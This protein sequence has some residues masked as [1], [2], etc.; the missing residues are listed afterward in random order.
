[1][2]LSRGALLSGAA[3]L[4]SVA[5]APLLADDKGAPR[6]AQE[7]SAKA[8]E[9][10]GQ[11]TPE[12]K[13]NLT[14]GYMAMPMLG[15]TPP[16]GARPGAGYVKGVP[17]LNVPPLWETDASLGVTWLDGARGTGG[18]QLPSGTAQGATWNPQL[19]EEGGR[20]IGSEAHAKGFNVLLAGGINL[21]R[22]ARN[23]RTFEYLGEDPLHSGIMGG[24]VVR[25]IQSNPVISTL[26]HFT[27]N[28]QE[29]G[30]QIMN[31]KISEAALRESDLLAFEIAIEQGDPGAIMCAYDAI[32]GPLSCG[33]EFLLTKVL[34]DDWGYKGFVMSDW[35][36]VD[37]LDFAM[38][39]LDQQSGSELDPEPYLGKPL[40][41]AAR[42]DPKWA[43]RLSEMA[44]HVLW[45]IYRFGLD[46]DPPTVSKVDTEADARVARK[47]AEEGIVL[48]TN[49]DGV[50]PFGSDVKSVA[51][52]GGHADA[53]TLVGGG[54]SR[55]MP[56]EG[57]SITVPHLR[58]DHAAFAAFIDAQYNRSSPLTA[59][60][61]GQPE[62]SFTFRDGRYTSEAAA[63]AARSDV[64]VVF[65]TQ[66]QT[67]GY[68][69]PDLS[70]PGNQDALIE[71]VA[72]A[73]PHTI[74]VLETGG[75]VLMP[76]KDKVAG[77]VEAWYPGARGGEAISDILFGKVNPSGRLPITFPQSVAQLPRPKLDGQGTIEPSFLGTGK[78]G[79]TF[80]VN[81]DI[82]GSDVGYRWFARKGEKPLFA[83][84]HGLTYTSFDYGPLRVQG[85]TDGIVKASFT[86]TNT[87]ERAGAEV[88][89]LYL[90]SVN[91]KP[92][93]RLAGFA[94]RDLEPGQKVK[95]NLTVDPRLLA[96]WEDGGW[97]L[98]GGEYGFALGKDAESLGQVVTIQ[99]GARRW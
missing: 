68:D 31:A 39:G 62:V 40:L 77:I 47:V 35:G 58:G 87:G 64:A 71:A 60:R 18:T 46:T 55:V 12:E 61:E 14:L 27:I 72:A 29:T 15:S 82:E 8:A 11:M 88:A 4:M 33:S 83:F 98:A 36:A 49:P 94:K 74:V 24:A 7:A 92:R 9:V 50:L 67:E 95:V 26:K 13:T 38:A 76:W 65:V 22:E 41:E 48:L 59:M 89:Q 51:V 56:D 3:I 53:G 21:M 73:N 99:L 43:A 44:R 96:N 90:T 78:P 23:G 79:E 97:S 6:T 66:F 32:N 85:G 42:R 1:M 52:I 10:E 69:V 34:R 93:Q 63:L 28:P 5:T 16:E 2:I 57:P 30:R 84:G 54:S 70:L 17:R 81:Y 20:M 80:D 86:I 45:P 91:G 75:P 19:L 25:G 37:G